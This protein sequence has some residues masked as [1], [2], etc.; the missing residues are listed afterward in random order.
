[1]IKTRKGIDITTLKYPE[2]TS[3][4]PLVSNIS[5]DGI[6]KLKGN[7]TCIYHCFDKFTKRKQNETCEEWLYRFKRE[8]ILNGRLITPEQYESY[9]KGTT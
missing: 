7:W 4:C 6:V 5:P 9:F 1:M 3:E 2:C 8:S